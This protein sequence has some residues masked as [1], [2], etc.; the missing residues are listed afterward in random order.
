M[1]KMRILYPSYHFAELHTHINHDQALP[2]GRTVVHSSGLGDIGAYATDRDLSSYTGFVPE[3]D[4][5]R[6]QSSVSATDAGSALQAQ[7]N[8]VG[9][10]VDSMTSPSAERF[11]VA[12]WAYCWQESVFPWAGEHNTRLCIELDAAVPYCDMYGGAI[13]YAYVA[14]AIRDCAN[15]TVF[16]LQQSL[17]DTRGKRYRLEGIFPWAEMNSLIALGYFG[18]KYYCSPLPKTA[19]LSDQIWCDWRYFGVSISITQL[20]RVIASAN[21]RLG[22]RWSGNPEQYR[23][24]LIGVGPEVCTEGKGGFNERHGRIGMKIRDLR[25]SLQSE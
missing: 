19:I 3:G 8:T 17:F 24:E 4:L 11:K 16:W 1:M 23:L 7:G 22:Q 2:V 10:W 25:V 5:A 6:Y 12:Q 9:L 21:T 14:I 20:L 15:Q 18:G 13:S